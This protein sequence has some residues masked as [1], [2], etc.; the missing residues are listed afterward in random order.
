MD[1]RAA[2]ASTDLCAAPFTPGPLSW[3]ATFSEIAF[4]QMIS[5][6]TPN[7]NRSWTQ[8]HP[9]RRISAVPPPHFR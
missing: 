9:S 2:D 4:R 8:Q 7:A 6:S 1:A 5:S 3:G